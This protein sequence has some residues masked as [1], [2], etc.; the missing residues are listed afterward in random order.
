LIKIIYELS[1]QTY[2]NSQI[3]YEWELQR[4]MGQ[5]WNHTWW[6]TNLARKSLENENGDTDVMWLVFIVVL[7]IVTTLLDKCGC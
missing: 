1:R 2:N 6:I 5:Y 3:Y 4:P 7:C